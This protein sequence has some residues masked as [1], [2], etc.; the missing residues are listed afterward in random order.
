[1]SIGEKVVAELKAGQFFGEIALLED[2]IRN[3]DVKSNSYCDLYTF[4]K[5]DF[6]E[7]IEKYPTLGD[8]FQERYKK[9][10][11]DPEP[12]QDSVKAA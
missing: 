4:N 9:R 12:Q 8:K 11:T 3:A 2:T 10:S 1:V 5:A 6:I 7:V